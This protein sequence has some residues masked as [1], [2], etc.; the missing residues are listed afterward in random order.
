MAHLRGHIDDDPA[1]LGDHQPRRRLRDDKRR[2]DVEPEQQVEGR[3]VDLE[4]RL[5]PVETGIVDQNVE[6][7][8]TGNASRTTSERVTSKGSGRARPPPHWIS[9]A[10]SSSSL[11]GAA[12]QHQLGAGSRRAPTRR[13]GRSR[14][15]RRSPAQSCRRAGTLPIVSRFR[16]HRFRARAMSPGRLFP[17]SGRKTAEPRTETVGI[18]GVDRHAACAP[19]PRRRRR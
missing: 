14:A 16:R 10:T 1:A 19:A 3:L 8:E 13:R 4:K 17:A 5:R 12:H 9:P 15:R 11:G 18:R 2:P 6:P 7:A